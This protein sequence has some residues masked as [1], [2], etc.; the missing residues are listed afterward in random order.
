MTV[1]AL[2]QRRAELLF[3]LC[4]AFL[5]C[6]PSSVCRNVWQCILT[7][8]LLILQQLLVQS[9]KLFIFRGCDPPLRFGVDSGAQSPSVCERS[10]ENRQQRL[11]PFPV[12]FHLPSSP[13]QTNCI[14]RQ[15]QDY[16]EEICKTTGLWKLKQANI[17]IMF[18]SGEEG[19]STGAVAW[20]WCWSGTVMVRQQE[21]GF[22][23]FLGQ[24][25]SIYPC[26]LL[27]MVTL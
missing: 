11:S 7:V 24:K 19:D 22:D 16:S 21:R 4:F 18:R 12:T 13:Q 14:D 6:S 3:F 20:L 2:L 23:V 15:K 26:K 1:R 8:M 17:E 25:L 9:S 10:L 27:W 5:V